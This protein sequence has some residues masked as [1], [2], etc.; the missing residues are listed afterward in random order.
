VRDR[1]TLTFDDG[2]G[3]VTGPL[4]DVLGRH[5]AVATFYW[6]GALVAGNEAMMRRAARAGHAIGVHGW[7]HVDHRDDPVMRAAEVRRAAD[8]IEG[9]CGVPV[10]RF[11]PP[12]GSTSA[13]LEGAVAAHGLETVLWDVDPRDWEDPGPDAIVERTLAALRPGAIV[14]LHERP[15]TVKAVD[16]LLA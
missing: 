13:E 10:R 9:V 4:L 2:P 15:G 1:L 14:L 5:R 3:E 16:R 12:Y 6:L 7:T 8:L 11:R